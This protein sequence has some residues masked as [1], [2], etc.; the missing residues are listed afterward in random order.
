[1]NIRSGGT[2]SNHLQC[3]Q[4]QHPDLQVIVQHLEY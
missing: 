3:K 2:H 4:V 1:M